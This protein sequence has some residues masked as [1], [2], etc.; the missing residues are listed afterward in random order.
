M[1]AFSSKITESPTR[2]GFVRLSIDVA[3][4]NPEISPESY[5]F[6]VDQ[7]LKKY[8]SDS[9]NPWVLCL[10]P[11]AM[12][13]QE[14]LHIDLP[15][16]AE[17]LRHAHE[18]MRVWS[19]W[20][21]KLKPMSI[22]ADKADPLTSENPDRAL[23]FFSGGVDA[24]FT[25]L[26][27]EQTN[28]PYEKIHIDDLAYIW[29]FDI[30][31]INTVANEQKERSLRDAARQMGKGF[32]TIA[33]NIKLT[34]LKN[35]E[36]EYM[37]HGAVLASVAYLLEKRYG[38]AFIASSGGYHDSFPQGS[39]LALMPLFS[40]RQML[41][42]QSGATFSRADK[43][44]WISRSKVA[45]NHLHVCFLMGDEKNCSQ[46]LK[47]YRTM[48]V[49]DLFGA[50]GSFKTF[51]V[52]QFDLKKAGKIFLWGTDDVRQAAELKFLASQKNRPDIVKAMSDSLRKTR[53]IKAILGAAAHLQKNNL[54]R[55]LYRRI[56]N[57]LF[58]GFIGSGER[59]YPAAEDSLFVHYNEMH[60]IISSIAV[61]FGEGIL[62]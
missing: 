39:H 18:L 58:R 45:Q 19:F 4:D 5:W 46:C 59:Y 47:C 22:H 17:L 34:Q 1:R 56:E 48:L 32:V 10:A 9:G 28:D 51:D 31:H 57:R 30:P 60:F 41:V 7:S 21:P 36:W 3:Y 40:S 50:L 2:P 53:R 26:Y 12:T 16:D 61:L 33:T 11:V 29:G 6:E 15:V 27:H 52:S 37:C 35:C 13:L 43:I 24:F 25:A 14:P 8:L 42:K 20:F 38:K 44:E 54:G 49:L 62:I 55:E 23:S